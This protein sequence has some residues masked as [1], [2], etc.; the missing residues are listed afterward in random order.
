MVE[1][2][3]IDQMKTKLIKDKIPKT[4]EAIWNALLFIINLAR[5]EEKLYEEIPISIGKERSKLN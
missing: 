4:C 1:N 3:K 2:E 5:W